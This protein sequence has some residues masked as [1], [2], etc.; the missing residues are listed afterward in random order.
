[1]SRALILPDWAA[2]AVREGRKTEHRVLMNPQPRMYEAGG[3]FGLVWGKKCGS[4]DRIARH[5]PFGKVGDVIPVKEAWRIAEK[6]GLPTLDEYLTQPRRCLYYADDNPRYR[7]KDTW[8]SAESLPPEFVRTHVRIT[9]IGV[10]LLQ[11]IRWQDAIAEGVHDPR[12]AKVRIDEADPRSPVAQFRAYWNEKY[13]KRGLGFDVRQ[14]VWKLG[15]TLDT[16]ASL[17]ESQ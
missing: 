10:E 7:D 9:A 1:M 13:T 4:P 12:R 14:F 2:L 17:G 6:S 16:T 11:D 5:C 15:I 8:E 3:G